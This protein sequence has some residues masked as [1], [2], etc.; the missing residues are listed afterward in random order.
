M[1]FRI[2]SMF[3]FGI[4]KGEKEITAINSFITMIKI[5]I[6]NC[7]RTK[8]LAAFQPRVRSC[9]GTLSPCIINYVLISLTPTGDLQGNFV[10]SYVHRAGNQDTT[11]WVICPYWP[12]SEMTELGFTPRWFGRFLKNSYDC[13]LNLLIDK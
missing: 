8:I 9:P 1:I 13:Y 3:K 7:I 5:L 11:G 10:T 4:G 12:N 6:W 2:L